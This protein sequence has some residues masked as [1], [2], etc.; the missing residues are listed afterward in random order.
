MKTHPEDAARA[1][2][3]VTPESAA[4]L[5]QTVTPEIS[6][7]VLCHM[8]PYAGACCL[9]QMND[10]ELLLLLHGMDVQTGISFLRY[11]DAIH[12][13]KLLKQLPTKNSKAYRQ[14]LSYPEDTVGAWMHPSP[15]ALSAETTCKDALEQIRRSDESS[16]IYIFVISGNN[17]RLTGYVE[18][19][20]LLRSEP[21][22][23][24]GKLTRSVYRVQAQSKLAMLQEHVGWKETSI[25]P[26]LD[27]SNRLIGMISYTALRRALQ[28]DGA[29]VPV[30]QNSTGMVTGMASSYW[31]GV[32][33]L[34]QS[35]VSLIPNERQKG[36][37]I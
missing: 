10:A 1:L 2:E 30:L 7:P 28:T 19:A 34:V 37:D 20:D 18:I 35:V 17:Q 12:R 6:L 16:I 24:L 31:F 4:A 27:H 29:T 13:N 14:L 5:L 32:S 21:T 25:L 22:V 23:P 11:F 9:E 26:V 33:T 36:E 15:F 3:Q 8:V